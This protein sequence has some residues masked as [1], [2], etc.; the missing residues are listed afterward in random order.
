M[1][2]KAVTVMWM[3]SAN[4]APRT[5]SIPHV[6]LYIFLGLMV[7]SWL[8][9]GIG[10]YLGQRLYRDSAALQAQNAE[11]LHE[12][13]DL[14]TLR[15]TIKQIQ[16]DES[17]IRD[18]L[19][20]DGGQ[21]EESNL[22]QGGEPSPDL[23]TIAVKDAMTI[24]TVSV[25]VETHST[26]LVNRAQSLQADLRELVGAMWDQKQALDSTPSIV[27]VQSREY[28]LASG[29]GWRRSPFTGVKE[30]HNGLDICGRK[31]T[32]IIAPADGVVYR[33]SRHKY[34]G[35]YIRINHGK[36]V[37]TTYGHLAGY[38][39]EK[40]QKVKRGEVI[41]FMGNTGRSTGT[42][43]HYA[44]RVNKKYVNPFH[45]I[46]NTKKNRLVDFYL[47][48]EGSNPG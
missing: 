8:L 30:F 9:L 15:H 18:F 22:G 7:F 6:Y 3:P 46:L 28:W 10:G 16:K 29:F 17:V 35:R 32:P 44:V 13:K 25:P 21:T 20:L 1:K 45:Y 33:R 31:H 38:N 26:P 24:S 47:K 12:V 4:S 34:L 14:D 48:A 39:V 41:A 23:S 2:Q 19:G 42:H 37:T 27:P 11:L 5:F 43:L 36:G 40:G